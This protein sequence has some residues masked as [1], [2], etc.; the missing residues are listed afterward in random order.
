MDLPKTKQE[1]LDTYYLKNE[2]LEICKENNLPRNGSKENL[3]KY[4]CDFIENKK[5]TK[6]KTK[7]N[8]TDN[9]FMPELD[10]I[11][12]IHYSN[13]EIHRK[14]FTREIGEHFKYNVQFMNWMNKNKGKKTYKEAMEI[15]NK[16]LL[17]KKLGKKNEIGTQFEYNQYTR[18]FFENNPKLS[19][20]ECIK[21]WKYKKEQMGKHKYEKGDLKILGK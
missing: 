7:I 3:I 18:D 17:E 9:D 14:F 8:K 16:I 6:I 2:L 5:I 10:K 11:I 1:F 4:I 21:C 19:R 15:W 12:D 20:K 13:N